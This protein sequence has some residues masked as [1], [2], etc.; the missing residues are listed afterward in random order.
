MVTIGA[1][2]CVSQGRVVQTSLPIY[3]CL[4]HY[5]SLYISPNLSHTVPPPEPI[6]A[7]YGTNNKL[8]FNM[9]LSLSKLFS[10][11]FRHSFYPPLYP[12]SPIQPKFLVFFFCMQAECSC[13]SPSEVSNKPRPYSKN[14]LFKNIYLTSPKYKIHS[15]NTPCSS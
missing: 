11:L 6:T 2:Y 12:F 4:T 14:P 10:L 1:L 5:R 7:L 3:F 9:S 8:P 15:L 13:H